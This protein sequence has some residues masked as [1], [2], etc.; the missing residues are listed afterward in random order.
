MSFPEVEEV[1]HFEKTP[2]RV[3]KKI[4]MT[5]DEIKNTATVK[6]SEVDQSAFSA[7]GKEHIYPVDNKWG[8]QGW[9]I[10]EFEVLHKDLLRDIV[11]TAYCEIAPK[12]LK[13]LVR[14]NS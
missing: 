1:P 9:T 10:I 14:P 7:A 4:F 3:K 8:K 6:L 5:Y 2:F 13:K 12:S 11:T